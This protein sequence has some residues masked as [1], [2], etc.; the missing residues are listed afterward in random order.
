MT[1]TS[2]VP[3]PAGARG[4]L[5]RSAGPFLLLTFAISW[6]L[7]AL[8]LGLGGDI[9]DPTVFVLFNAGACGPALAAGALALLGRGGERQARL[10]AAPGWLPA[11][12]LVGAVPAVVAAAVAPLFGAAPV[13]AGAAAELVAAA[14]G[15]LPFLGLFLVAGPLA[16]E[17]G[18][19][20][21]LQ[22]R[23]RR[24]LSPAATAA[25]VGGIWALWHVPLFLLLGT[26]QS[27]M[28]GLLSPA[29]LLFL[30]AM[31]PLSVGYWFVSERLR[32][33]VPGAVLVHTAGNISLTLLAVTGSLAG[34]L[35]FV[36]TA[37]VMA[38][39][40]LRRS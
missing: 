10:A 36:A 27:A 31:P 5:V 2:A 7:W 37:V 33:G 39:V 26:S 35:A 30:A 1:T 18:W 38:A 12:L 4:S 13:D 8:G 11:A 21:H 22:P 9:A 15:L 14:G 23:L 17:F 19:R 29:A 34:G 6:G 20:G 3:R 28:G 32:G 25:V 16:E 24:V 40:L